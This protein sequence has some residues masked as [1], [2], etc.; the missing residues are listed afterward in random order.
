MAGMRGG[1]P[2][3]S[4]PFTAEL[5]VGHDMEQENLPGY[6]QYLM[7]VA[8]YPHRAIDVRLL[9]THIS[10]IVLVGECVYKWKKPVNLGFLDFSTLEDRRYFCEQELS[11]NR[12]LCPDVYLDVVH[13]ARQDDSF[14]LGGAGEVVEYG[15]RMARLPEDRMMGEVMERGALCQNEIDRIVAR[16][17]P[18]Y[19]QAEKYGRG[20]GYGSAAAVAE[21]IQE[22]LRQ[23]EPFID[24]DILERR[25]FARIRDYSTGFLQREE[26]FLRRIDAGRIRDCHGDLHSGN[27]CLTDEVCIFDCIEFSNRLRCGDVAA[28][29][30]FLA[31]DLDLHGLVPLSEYFIERFILCSGDTGLLD[32]LDFYKCYRACVRGKIN[33]LTAVDPGLESAAATRCGMLA[34]RCFALAESYLPTS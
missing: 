33:L 16:L 32:V 15:V 28:D 8:S 21:N 4:D 11:L 20:E 12:R 31:M 5:T 14:C 7:D 1:F 30:A 13:I 19:A 27:I 22:N 17:V 25:Q 24:D 10:Y 6:I 23:I 3:S 9:Q 18:F 2:K 26:I 34:K 29:V